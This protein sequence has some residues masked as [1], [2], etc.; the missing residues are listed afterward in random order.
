MYVLCTE[1]EVELPCGHVCGEGAILVGQCE[2]DL[3]NLEEVD[4]T[5][6]CLVVVVG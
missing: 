3:D 6:H 1:L 4:I 5:S 2:T